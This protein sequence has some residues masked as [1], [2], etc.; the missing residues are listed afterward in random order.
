MS[1]ITISGFAGGFPIRDVRSLPD[2]SAA[3][4][5]NLRP[6]T[7]GLSGVRRPRFIKALQAT[8]QKVYR[9]PTGAIS[10]IVGA[11]YWM[12][13][14]DPETSVVRTPIVND[15][16]ERY[17]WT[18]PA[19]GGMRYA[20]KAQILA[21][22]VTG[23][24]AGVQQPVGSP[25]VDV[26]PGTGDL[27]PETGKNTVP[28]VTRSYVITFVS[29]FGEE[30]QPSNPYEQSGAGDADWVVS[31]IPQPLTDPDHALVTTI[32]LYRTV[33]AT[34]G[35]TTFYRV[36]DLD[37]GTT[38]Y[39]DRLSDS[40]VSGNSILAST[41]WVGPPDGLEGLIL[42]PGGIMVGFIRNN[43]YFSE[44]FQPHAWPEEY[45]LTV[46][47]PIVGLGVFG[48]TCVVCTEGHP[49]AVTGITPAGM[50]LTTNDTALPCLS[51]HS[52]VSA[53]EGVYYAAP[54]GLVLINSGAIT[55]VTDTFV[56]RDLWFQRY[57]ADTVR[58]VVV[59][60]AY[61]A[62]RTVDGVETG[63][64]MPTSANYSYTSPLPQ[65]QTGI[66]DLDGFAG[67]SWVGMDMWSG[68]PWMISE[69]SLY[70]WMPA[71]TR[72]SMVRW[73]SREYMLP[74]PSNFGAGIIYFDEP[75]FEP[76][77][78]ED[79]VRLRVWADRKLVFDTPLFTRS[80]KAFRLPSGFKAD[81]WQLEIE[82][83][84]FVH[85]VTLGGT[86]ADLRKV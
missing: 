28:A 85:S 55:L 64:L 10:D 9:I 75:D 45:T 83:S 79:L 54:Q 22:N 47:H 36:I 50:S 65:Q 24:K 71:D 60:G 82:A 15:S 44:P 18:S 26:T 61:T 39:T 31:G 8:T 53:P 63:F 74:T 43:L 52:I 77:P 40:V 16:H 62:I 30:G 81:C 42:M 68:R 72:R 78:G 69:S 5:V 14:P 33:T 51:R 46:Q 7:G 49:A 35:V 23:M 76:D 86:I 73:R 67:A 59:Y 80:G 48:N 38:Q 3:E 6:T 32:R 4:V 29:E 37:V 17:Y 58:A 19:G 27:D 21:G 70:E 2:N 20:T 34:S 13:F 56:G 11:S 84:V 12:E 1:G 66:I 57:G 25:V 41:S